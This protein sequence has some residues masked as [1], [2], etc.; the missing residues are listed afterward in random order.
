MK[1]L[2][3]IH[4]NEQSREAWEAYSEAQRAEGIRAHVELVEDLT[5]SGEMVMSEALADP[6]HAKRVLVRDGETT[7]TDGPFTELKEHL[8]GF[9][10]VECETVDRAIEHAA[11]IPEAAYGNVEVRPILSRNGTEA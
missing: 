8:A 10:L 7:T 4:H 9:Y 5:E 11:R 1:Y 3:L 2:I 6:T